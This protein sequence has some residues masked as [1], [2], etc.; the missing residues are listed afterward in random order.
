MGI[1]NVGVL[2]YKTE[3]YGN[4]DRYEEYFLK[5]LGHGK[6]TFSDKSSNTDTKGIWENGFLKTRK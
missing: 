2:E 5:G 6:G 4:G 1:E 3:I